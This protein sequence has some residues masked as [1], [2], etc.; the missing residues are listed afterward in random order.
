MEDLFS[1]MIFTELTNFDIQINIGLRVGHS[2]IME[3]EKSPERQLSLYLSPVS[4]FSPIGIADL[5][6]EKSGVLMS[7]CRT[8]ILLFPSSF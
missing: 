1:V 4:F 5:R 2:L 8:M 3:F 7:V 6:I